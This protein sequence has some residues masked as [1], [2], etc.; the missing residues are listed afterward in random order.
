MRKVRPGKVNTLFPFE[1]FQKINMSKFDQNGTLN[2][3][4]AIKII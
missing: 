2:L 1:I 4:S 3:Q